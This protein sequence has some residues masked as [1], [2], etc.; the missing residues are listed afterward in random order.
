MIIILLF[1]TL[2]LFCANLPEI[3]VVGEFNKRQNC[4]ITENNISSLDASITAIQGRQ[5]KPQ[6]ALQ[7]RI[8]VALKGFDLKKYSH[9][10]NIQSLNMLI[11]ANPNQSLYQKEL[12]EKMKELKKEQLKAISIQT[13]LIAFAAGIAALLFKKYCYKYLL[14]LIFVPLSIPYY[15]N[16][17]YLKE[18]NESFLDL[19]PDLFLFAQ[20]TLLIFK[21]NLHFC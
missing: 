18:K 21:L 15:W 5:S 10:Q 20:T 7:W 1:L 17:A 13:H 8:N 4:F 11:N 9:K 3:Q 14:F 16:Y 6:I 2:N 19:L 12:Q